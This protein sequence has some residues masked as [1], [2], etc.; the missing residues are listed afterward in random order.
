MVDP[1]V[2]TDWTNKPNPEAEAFIAAHREAVS[3]IVMAN[4]L[5]C[6]SC[7]MFLTEA[8][9]HSGYR[10]NVEAN[11][12]ERFF[13]AEGDDLHVAF[14]IVLRDHKHSC[15]S[16]PN[17]MALAETEYEETAGFTTEA[18]WIAY[19]KAKLRDRQE[20][21]SAFGDVPDPDPMA[22]GPIT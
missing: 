18:E 10:I 7:K 20:R 22:R 14:G 11:H 1:Q 13:I 9:T 5:R 4:L 6:E 2:V 16:G 19:S 17:A 12:F 8:I 3:K 15:R 21:W